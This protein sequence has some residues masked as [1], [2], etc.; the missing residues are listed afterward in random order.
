M[1]ESLRRQ[2]ERCWWVWRGGE[3]IPVILHPHVWHEFYPLDTFFLQQ[4]SVFCIFIL[5]VF[6][7][8]Q[9]AGLQPHQLYRR[10]SFPSFTWPGSAVS[11]GL[12]S[13][14]PANNG[15][16]LTS[17]EHYQ[18]WDM[19][20]LLSSLTFKRPHCLRSSWENTASYIRR[21]LIIHLADRH[22][23]T[24]AVSPKVGMSKNYEYQQKGQ[25]S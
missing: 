9:P 23:C 5:Y 16:A 14:P 6:V 19:E 20:Q 21:Y 12:F 3:L 17:D 18:Q 22:N 10:W 7:C 1:G 2:R 4:F 24:E 15:S 13:R 25:I 11:T 8:V